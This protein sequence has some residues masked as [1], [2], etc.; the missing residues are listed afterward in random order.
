MS[1]SDVAPRRARLLID[2]T[3][4]DGQSA[5]MKVMDKFSGE[6]FGVA[7]SASRE[8]VNQA[9][10]AAR[11]SFQRERLDPY[12]RYV[13]LSKVAALLE[14]RR[15]EFAQTIVAEAGLP[16][17]DASNEVS[18][19]VQ[20]F[21][22]SA[23]EGKRLTGEG[24]PIDGAPG[25]AHRMAF[26]IRVP[27]G[28]VCG[29]TAF[30]SPLNMVAHKVAPALGSGNTI[31]MKPPEV[32]PFSAVMLFET[33]LAAGLPPGHANLILGAGAETGGYLVENPYIAFYTFTGSVAVGKKIRAAIG[34]RPS[35]ME[36]GSIAATIVCEDADLERAASRIANSGFRRAGQSCT[37]TQRL[38]VHEEVRELFL[39]LLTAAS[40]RL[41][42]GDPRSAATAVGPMISEKEAARAEAWVTEAIA[43]GAR[44]IT[45]GKREGSL[46]YPTILTDVRPDMRVMCEEIFAPVLSVIP[47]RSF[48]EVIDQ[49]NATPYGLAAGVF[50]RDVNRAMSAARR[51]HVGIVH[52]NEP[53]SSRVDLMP[54][55]GVKES[56]LGREGPK[57]AMQ[58]MTE[59]R[60]ITLSL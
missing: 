25:N 7:E 5:P 9:V 17:S 3:W 29:I 60:V 39:T 49:V 23:E 45:G 22:V 59:E 51:L 44:L 21:I 16:I 52:I 37:S 38:F 54:F 55:S 41:S 32:A 31:V 48:D 40:Q 20:T 34:L 57:Y 24:V 6:L 56:G 33:L 15:K 30:N 10:D 43:Q 58:E 12:Q 50:T 26:T 14:E 42:V 18:R 13:I 36:L 28:V 2:G 47:F 53:S 19:T 35:A 1:L 46:L 4:T 27:R 11:R 8:Q